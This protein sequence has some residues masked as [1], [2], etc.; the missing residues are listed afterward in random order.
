MGNMGEI[1]LPHTP[2]HTH[3]QKGIGG[4]I[5]GFSDPEKIK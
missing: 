5:W 1:G 4:E 2:T 3:K